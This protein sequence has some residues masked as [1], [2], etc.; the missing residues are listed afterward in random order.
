MCHEPIFSRQEQG[1]VY[2]FSRYWQKIDTFNG[3]R[4]CRIHTHFPDFYIEDETSGKVEG[5]EFEYGLRDFSTHLH[6][7]LEKLKDESIK[8]LYIVYWDEDT[9]KT[10]LRRSIKKQ[11]NGKVIFVCLRD[12]FSPCV[13][14]DID[15]LRTAWT[16]SPTKETAKAYPFD[17]INGD[18]EKLLANGDF[19]GL[20]IQGGLYRTIGFNKDTSDYIECDHW[21]KI[22]LFTTETPLDADNIP[23]K[24]FVK[25]N[26]HDAFVGCFEIEHAFYINKGSEAVQDY[27]KNY[28]FYPYHPNYRESTCFVYS[29]FKPFAYEQGVALRTFLKPKYAIDNRGSKKIWNPDHITK[30]DRIVG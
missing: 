18:T 22:H 20:P 11:F 17:R 23:S 7:D 6:G 14:P 10:R 8:L 28:Y 15:C 2:L 12:Y 26:A 27:F 29:D 21:K 16:F 13:D 1:V 3:K 9:D 24:L 30:I 19:D 4:V 25:P 5:I